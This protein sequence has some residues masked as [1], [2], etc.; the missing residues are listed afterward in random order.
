MTKYKLS[1]PVQLLLAIAAISLLWS[2]GG[3]GAH[4]AH[5]APEDTVRISRLKILDD[6]LATIGAEAKPTL[7]KLMREAKDSTEWSEYAVRLGRF[8]YKSNQPDSLHKYISAAKDYI[9][10]QPETTRGDNVLGLAYESEAGW[11]QLMRYK[12][13]EVVAL[14][15]KAFDKLSRS[16][17][18][19]YVSD[20]MANIGDTY[21]LGNDIPK[22]AAC[23]RRALFIVDSLQL[24]KEKNITLYMGLARIY[25]HLGDLSEAERFY[26]QTEQYF[27]RMQYNMQVY[28]L[29]SFGSYF[30]KTKDYN[31]SLAYFNRM[32]RLVRT[33]EGDSCFDMA[34]CRINTADV[35]L[36]L[37]NPG[38]AEKY[39]DAAESFF[40]NNNI[41]IG[42]YYS[43][44]IRMG[45]LLK[46]RKYGEIKR[47]LD[48]ERVDGDI[49]YSIR[50]IRNSYLRE[51]YTAT[52]NPAAALKNKMEEDSEE[53]TIAKSN[54]YMRA[55][56]VIQRF[57]EDTL[58]LHHKIAM[59]EKTSREQ[60]DENVIITLSAGLLILA[61]A[62][63]IWWMYTRKKEVTGQME[64]FMLRLENTRNRISP[65]FIFN[66]LNN[67]I[68]TAGQKEKD[69]LMAL[70]QLI[71]QS[72]DI[73][74][75][76]FITL[77]EE[78]DFVRKYVEVQSYVLRPDFEFTV[79]V[80][81]DI[82]GIYIPSMSVQILAENAIKHGL[83][84]L[85]RKQTL[86]VT[87]TRDCD[88]TTV[89]V[90]D[91]GRGFDCTRGS[92]NGL[93][94]NIIRQTIAAV[95]RRSKRGRMDMDITN[96]RDREGNVTGCRITITVKG[97]INTDNV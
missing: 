54:S 84:G 14:H 95:N 83:K 15:R 81:D 18:K 97:K 63:T 8:Y 85:D 66:V 69:E 36:N 39:L 37:G 28:F 78:L 82:T 88:T 55:S 57:S 60:R 31:K 96:P 79:S 87:V 21:F 26:R 32:E 19:S 44:S 3:E 40:R 4:D 59:A 22:A 62:F 29:S 24:P 94:M 80:P 77:C 74:R 30:Y 65:H 20:V 53:D 51:Y 7:E 23:Y 47:L 92:G 13:E 11:K 67:R 70:A 5:L 34:L 45:I 48:N 38:M 91:N 93:G 68:Y 41:G 71:R 61:L 90:E 76:T 49:E 12:T 2:C 33:H 6:S 17:D 86:A 58:A 73:S 16:G 35:Y 42:I 56:E 64:R 50:K 10:R 72:L 25:E 52:G 43:N 75:N 46:R 89:T 1:Y 27:S 9:G